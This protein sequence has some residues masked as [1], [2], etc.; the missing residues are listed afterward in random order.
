MG[1]AIHDVLTK[2]NVPLIGR[3]VAYGVMFLG[4]LGFL[5]KGIIQ[6]FFTSN[7]IGS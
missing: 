3:A 1:Y 6:I 7:G 5:A 2:N 4:A